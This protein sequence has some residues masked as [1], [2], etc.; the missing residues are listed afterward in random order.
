MPLNILYNFLEPHTTMKGVTVDVSIPSGVNMGCFS[1]RVVEGRN[2]LEVTIRWSV[3][4]V[5]FKID[6]KF[7]T[8]VAGNYQTYDP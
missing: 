6:K 3:P 1:L 4:L 2:F 5:D 8:D 7:L